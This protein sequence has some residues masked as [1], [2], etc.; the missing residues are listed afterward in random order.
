MLEE[1]ALDQSFPW[2]RFLSVSALLILFYFTIFSL[3]YSY[4]FVC[5]KHLSL[6]LVGNFSIWNT[7]LSALMITLLVLLGYVF[8]YVIFQKS[9]KIRWILASGS[10]VFVLYAIYLDIESYRY[11]NLVHGY[12]FLQDTGYSLLFSLLVF[13]I[14]LAGMLLAFILNKYLPKFALILAILL[15]AYV[16][17]FSAL[18]VY[19]RLTTNPINYTWATNPIDN[20]P[21]GEGPL[22]K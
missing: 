6:I 15:I 3:F 17:T 12:N 20:P 7:L 14:F 16:V 8:N 9:M 2:K 1:S 4:M 13:S 19:D 5:A 10:T 11:P 22:F 18:A 21:P